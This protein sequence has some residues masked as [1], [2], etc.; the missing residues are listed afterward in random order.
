MIG[1]TTQEAIYADMLPDTA[2]PVYVPCGSASTL[3][4]RYEWDLYAKKQS[5]PMVTY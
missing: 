3:N 1:K 2:P 5:V 4:I